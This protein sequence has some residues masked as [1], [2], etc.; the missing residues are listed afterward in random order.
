[1]FQENTT[2]LLQ[3]AALAWTYKYGEKYMWKVSFNSKSNNMSAIKWHF[4]EVV[5]I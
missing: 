4:K 3:A 2:L 1:M 5:L